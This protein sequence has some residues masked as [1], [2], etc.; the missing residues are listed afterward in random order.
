[1]QRD[2][3]DQEGITYDTNSYEVYMICEDKRVWYGMGRKNIIEQHHR[4]NKRYGERQNGQL[5][6][7]N[8]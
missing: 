1:M 8:Y 6:K 5:I 7:K 4:V 3:Q 2:W